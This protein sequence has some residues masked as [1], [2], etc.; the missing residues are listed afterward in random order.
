V[1][2]SPELI[3]GRRVLVVEDGPS[4]THGGMPFGAATIAA[5]KFGAAE[6]VAPQPFAVGSIRDTY[7]RYPHIGSQLPSMG[8][9]EQ[10]IMDLEATINRADCDLVVF[11][12]PADLNGL[13][14]INKPAIR[15]RYEYKDHGPPLLK[16]V[17]AHKL[18][19]IGI[20]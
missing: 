1:A 12:T 10:Q 3:R 16:D 9:S 15:I 19:K 13:L 5:R 7:Q 8:Y 2:D 4:I 20:L 14:H 17:L 18:E 11:S 6:I